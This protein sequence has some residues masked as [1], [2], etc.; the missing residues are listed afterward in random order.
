MDTQILIQPKIQNGNVVLKIPKKVLE[1]ILDLSLVRNKMGSR[2]YLEKY[3]GCL[4]DKTLMDP[5]EYERKIRAEWNRD[6]E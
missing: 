3:R 1:R 2:K 5:L 4:K 6:L